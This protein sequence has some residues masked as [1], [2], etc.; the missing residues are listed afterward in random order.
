MDTVKLFIGGPSFGKTTLLC[1]Y[2]EELSKSKKCCI[3]YSMDKDDD[4]EIPDEIYEMYP[5]HIEIRDIITVEYLDSLKTEVILIDEAQ[6]RSKS[7]I[8]LLV[9]YADKNNIQI[10]LFGTMFDI[11]G[12]IIPVI[13]YILEV[14][15]PFEMIK[16]K[17]CKCDNMAF[18]TLHIDK[19]NHILLSP[20][21]QDEYE[22]L[23]LCRKCY[24]KYK[25]FI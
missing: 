3:I 18:T 21:E 4:P 15:I 9:E 11:Y 1:K 8:D 14:G 6:N 12:H 7:E 22:I 25:S 24:N 5:T 10:L 13:R 23:M 16:R 2:Y 20:T 19:N 17:C